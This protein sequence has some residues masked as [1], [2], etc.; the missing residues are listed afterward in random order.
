MDEK[1]LV[2]YIERIIELRVQTDAVLAEC[3]KSLK[4]LK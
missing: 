3:F 4:Q 2:S 1:T